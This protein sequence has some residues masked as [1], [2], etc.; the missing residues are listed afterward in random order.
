MDEELSYQIQQIR[1]IESEELLVEEVDGETSE[2]DDNV[3]REPT[4][5]SD[6]NYDTSL[7]ALHSYLG[8]I[9]DTHNR[10]SFLDGGAVIVV[11]LL[12]LKG[13]VLFP[14]ATL[15]LRV[16]QSNFVAAIEKALRHSNGYYTIGVIRVQKDP[17]NLRIKFA[18]TG[19]TAEIRQYRR[20]EDG[21]VNL[22]TRGQQRFRLR[23]HF[24]DVDGSPCGEV[25]IIQED[26]P[27]RTPRD[28]VGRLT[29][30]RR[31]RALSTVPLETKSLNIFQTEHYGCVSGTN[32][33]D[34]VD[35]VVDIHLERSRLHDFIGSLHTRR[36]EKHMHPNQG[37]GKISVS[38]RPSCEDNGWK[39]HAISQTCDVSRAYLP[40]WVYQ[41]YDSFTLAQKVAEQWKQIFKVPSMDAFVMKPDLLSFHIASKIPVSESIRQ[42]LLD[43]DGISYRLRRET[44]LLESLDRIRC[45]TCKTL[46]ARR[47]NMLVMS[48]EG[49]LGAYANPHGH[50][51]EIMTL[52]K[53]HELAVIGN[54]VR[55]YSWFPGYGWSI[56]ECARCGCQMGW[57]FTATNSKLKPRSFWGIRCSQLADTT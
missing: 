11:P 2:D 22:I 19:T 39:N 29:P 16:V 20:L 5:P 1:Q 27:L 48:R 37:V 21:S 9:E 26:V 8:D 57:L 23:R 33:D 28:T 50:V 53:A 30:L 56:A 35:E 45:K 36:E 51:H 12:Y 3:L 25:Q 42:E 40:N 46:I 41:M 31:F 54:P 10:L 15:P 43:I 6:L 4:S 38:D 18:T 13:V 47:S 14:E 49:P 44:K 52:L 34:K 7:A 32:D 55:E 24:I 17:H